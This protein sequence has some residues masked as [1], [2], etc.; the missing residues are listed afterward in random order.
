MSVRLPT[1]TLVAVVLL[2]AYADASLIDYSGLGSFTT[3]TVTEGGVTVTATSNG[4][5]GT[6][7]VTG[8]PPFVFGFGLGVIG[9]DSEGFGALISADRLVGFTGGESLRFA[10]DA[11]WATDVVIRLSAASSVDGPT[12]AVEGFAAVGSSLGTVEVNPITSFPTINISALFS[13][14]PVAAFTLTPQVD[15]TSLSVW[16]LSFT[17]AAVPEPA[18]AVLLGVGAA[19]LAGV[20]RLRRKA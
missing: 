7:N 17:P 16:R 11:G 2:P 14:Q 13:D 9:G 5:V 3:T 15:N 6:I 1:A 19:G 20:R 10:F 12:V 8:I 4:G 18:T